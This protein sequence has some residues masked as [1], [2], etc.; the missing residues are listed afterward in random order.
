LAFF[1][2]GFNGEAYCRFCNCSI[3]ARHSSLGGHEG[4]GKH[5]KKAPPQG[6]HNLAVVRRPRNQPDVKTKKAEL[7]MALGVACHCATLSIDHMGE[8]ITK[9]GQGSVIGNMKLHR[10]NRD[11]YYCYSVLRCNVKK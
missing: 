1:L 10:T 4:T 2:G 9:H 6:Q 11:F 3:T 7:Q 8:I 5:K